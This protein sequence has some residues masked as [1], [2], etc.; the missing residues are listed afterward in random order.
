MTRPGRV[1]SIQEQPEVRTF[2]TSS[3]SG[4]RRGS[5]ALAALAARRSSVSAVAEPR[6]GA[7]PRRRSSVF[8]RERSDSV[9][10]DD[11]SRSRR[12]SIIMDHS[13]SGFQKM[14]GNIQ[15]FMEEEIEQL[16]I[17]LQE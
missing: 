6:L 14:M 8:A 11:S 15:A 10:S 12:K 5:A 13:L 4:A 2:E 16:P 1:V 9:M 7:G 17:R 3:V